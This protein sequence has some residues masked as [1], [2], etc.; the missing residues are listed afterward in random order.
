MGIVARACIHHLY[1]VMFCYTSRRPL[2][3]SLA[4]AI[5]Y[6]AIR[7]P[8]PLVQ[9]EYGRQ[10]ENAGS[11]SRCQGRSEKVIHTGANYT[12]TWHCTYS[13]KEKERDLR[14]ELRS[15]RSKL[16]QAAIPIQGEQH[17]P[18]L[19]GCLLTPALE[20]TWPLMMVKTKIK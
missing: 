3:F 4:S 9:K 2:I 17:K 19:P 11:A 7:G 5:H 12:C 1:S 14:Y 10:S 8:E 16:P 13:R 6:G 18:S 20:A 15:R